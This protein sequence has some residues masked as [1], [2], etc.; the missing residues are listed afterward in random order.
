[1]SS[2]ASPRRNQ[3]RAPPPIPVKAHVER[4]SPSSLSVDNEILS[5]PTKKIPDALPTEQ[6]LDAAEQVTDD[7]SDSCSKSAGKSPGS[8]DS[9]DEDSVEEEASKPK[10]VGLTCQMSGLVCGWRIHFRSGSCFFQAYQARDGI[11]RNGIHRR[12]LRQIVKVSAFGSDNV[13]LRATQLKTLLVTS[14][15]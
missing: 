11:A 6:I 14:A 1:M 3:K 4:S 15:R 10:Y 7:D 13:V 5:L 2:G 8:D 9:N 12:S